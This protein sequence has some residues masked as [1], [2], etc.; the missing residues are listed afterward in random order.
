M[1]RKYFSQNNEEEIILKYFNDFQNISI[2]DIGANDGETFSNSRQAI[3][4]EANAILIEPAQFAFSKLAKLYKNNQ[5]VECLNIAIGKQ[6]GEFDFFE[7]DDNNLASSL[8][9]SEVKKWESIQINSSKKKVKCLTIQSL[10]E[11]TKS[12][13]FDLILIDAEG[14]DFEILQQIDLNSLG[15]RMICIEY[16]SKNIDKFFNYIHLQE[17][18]LVLRNAENLIFAKR[19]G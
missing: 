2:L 10:L 8:I 3:L 6:D 5:K 15:C 12:T 16:N 1:T 9:E 13:K 11:L 4:K 19:N 7:T 17:F 14:M 18:D